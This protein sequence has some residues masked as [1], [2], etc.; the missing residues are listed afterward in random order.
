MSSPVPPRPRHDDGRRVVELMKILVIEDNTMIR[1]SLCEMIEHWGYLVESASD[2]MIGWE[3]LKWEHYDLVV[4]DL[5]LPGLDGMDVCK[6][7]RSKAGQ[8]PLVL[9][10]TAR[11][12]ITDN[13]EGLEMGADD[14]LIKPFDPVLLKAR[15][16]ALL[17][18][19]NRPIQ[20]KWLWGLLTLQSDG[21]TANY[22]NYDLQLTAKEHFILEDLIKAA[23]HTRSKDQ[24]I[25]A[26][27]SGLD[28]P[29][30][31]SVKTH[32]KNLRAKLARA[33]APG[34]LIE[35]VY[36]VGFRMNR[37]HAA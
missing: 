30:D 8:Q 31:E 33:G 35:T 1:E 36:G 17:R 34:D 16:L 5:N 28:I 26:A 32:I 15:I 12:T 25:H 9:M 11:D 27:W 14:Y 23:G 20:D 3:L 2:G 4:L 19:A 37:D 18:R 6:R 10:L 7:L 24:L 13:V 29:S 22:G 21:A